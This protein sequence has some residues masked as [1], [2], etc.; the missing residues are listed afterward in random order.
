MESFVFIFV[1]G[2]LLYFCRCID[3]CGNYG[4]FIQFSSSLKVIS[5][6][7]LFCLFVFFWGGGF[8]WYTQV[9]KWMVPKIAYALSVGLKIRWL[10][11][12]Q[13]SKTPYHLKK[14]WFL[15]H[16]IMRH[17]FWRSGVCRVPIHCHSSQVYS[18]Q[19]WQY[20]FGFHLWV[21]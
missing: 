2:G 5:F 9:Y 18:D 19:E 20:L 13:K 7:F 16:L 12:L 11:P 21:K 10:Y 15:G 8:S 4:K 17:W 3:E 1:V 6:F 14:Y